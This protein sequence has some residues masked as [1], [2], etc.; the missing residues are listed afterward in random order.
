M[1]S[2]DRENCPNRIVQFWRYARGSTSRK[3]VSSNRTVA[4][5]DFSRIEV[6]ERW[7]ALQKS[8]LATRAGSR[9]LV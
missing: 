9:S 6:G 3:L 2:L 8:P 4:V 7:A 1:R 5:I